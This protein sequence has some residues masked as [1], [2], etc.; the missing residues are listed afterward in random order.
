MLIL[1][2]RPQET[3]TFP[4]L[5][6]TVRFLS[7][8]GEVVRL[9]VEAPPDVL[10]LRGELGEV[11]AERQPGGLAPAGGW[12]HWLRNRLNKIG[13]GLHLARHQVEAGK[14][15]DAELTLDDALKVLHAVEL[16]LVAAGPPAPPAPSKAGLRTLVVEDDSNERELLAGLLSMKGCDCAVAGDGEEALDYLDTHERP[17]FVLLD[18]L[19]PRCDGRQTLQRIRSNPR[20]SGLKVFAISGTSPDA[21]GIPQGSTGVDAWFCKPLNPLKLWEAMRPGAARSS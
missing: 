7:R 12:R 5:G 9:G 6:V 14:A 17:D 19:M 4:N 16:E 1:S 21:L 20:Y 10:V 11:P 15:A 2:R 3:I 13:L 8:K 18:M